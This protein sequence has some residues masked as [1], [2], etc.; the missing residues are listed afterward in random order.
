MIREEGKKTYRLSLGGYPYTGAR[1]NK[2][3]ATVHA[4]QNLEWRATYREL[5]DAY[6]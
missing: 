3:T 2:V 1:H 6:T 4:E 5:Q